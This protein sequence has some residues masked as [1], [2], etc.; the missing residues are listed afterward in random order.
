MTGWTRRS[1]LVGMAGGIVGAG[2]GVAATAPMS[3]SSRYSPAD[4]V[5]RAQGAVGKH[6]RYDM[7]AHVLP[8]ATLW[9]DGAAADCSSFALWCF[10]FTRHQFPFDHNDGCTDGIYLDA[11][12]P[13]GGI[14]RKVP[15]ACPG[16]IVIY[17]SYDYPGDSDAG[18]VGIVT[19]IEKKRFAITARSGP[20]AMTA[21]SMRRGA[22][23]WSTAHPR[24]GG[25]S[26]TRSRAG[27]TPSFCSTIRRRCWRDRSRRA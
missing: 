9:P 21:A 15:S 5:A 23:R 24:P 7:G 11:T 26:A 14:F 27:P 4:V 22:S 2:R 8:D 13:S 16:A 20:P 6:T 1:A 3:P 19:S 10:G 25:R 17:P 18:H 12:N